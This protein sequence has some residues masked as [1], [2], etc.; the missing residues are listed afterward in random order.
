MSY[1]IQTNITVHGVTKNALIISSSKTVKTAEISTRDATERK[2]KIAEVLKGFV[3]L[4]RKGVSETTL[5]SLLAAEVG[6]LCHLLQRGLHRWREPACSPLPPQRMA[7]SLLN[8]GGLL[9]NTFNA[10][11][12]PAISESKRALRVA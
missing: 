1:I 4:H 11:F 2:T 6:Q 12:K 8:E 7:A 3:K 5:G 9:S 10:V